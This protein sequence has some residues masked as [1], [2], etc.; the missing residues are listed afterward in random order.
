ME[1]DVPFTSACDLYL[2]GR[3]AESFLRRRTETQPIVIENGIVS[4]SSS[5]PFVFS[6]LVVTGEK[7]FKALLLPKTEN[8]D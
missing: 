2:D 7:N 1:L 4:E 3:P 8:G 5:A 6:P